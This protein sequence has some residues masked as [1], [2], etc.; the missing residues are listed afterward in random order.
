MTAGFLSAAVFTAAVILTFMMCADIIR[1]IFKS[2]SQK[3]FDSLICN[4]VGTAEYTDSCIF[5][6]STCTSSYA[7]AYENIDFILY[8]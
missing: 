7:A 2:V 4:A 6:G 3:C 5:E 1:V 8:E